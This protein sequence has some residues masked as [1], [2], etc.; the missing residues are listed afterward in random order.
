MK[1]T[2]QYRYIVEL[3]TFEYGCLVILHM[4][5]AKGKNGGSTDEEPVTDKPS[6]IRCGETYVVPDSCN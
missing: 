3:S 6:L 2:F 4:K 5:V 1:T